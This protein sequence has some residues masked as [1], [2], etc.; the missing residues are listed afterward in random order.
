M[1]HGAA[2]IYLSIL[3]TFLLIEGRGQSVLDRKVFIQANDIRLGTALQLIADKGGFK[4]SYNSNIIPL[5][6]VV[7]LYAE[8]VSIEEALDRLLS[9]QYEYRQAYNFVML[10]YAPRELSMVLQESVNYPGLFVI[11]GQ[12]VDSQTRLPVMYASV[13]EKKLLQTV[14][15]DR[16]GFFTLKLKNFPQAINITVSKENYKEIS[17]VFL[18]E[19]IVRPSRRGVSGEYRDGDLARVERTRLGRLLVTSEQKIQSLNIG[20]FIAQAPVQFSLGPGLST[21]GSLSG[22][23]IN[24]FSFNATGGY[25][26]GV[27]G[28]EIGLLFNIN[29]KDAGW[30]QF[31]GAFNLTGGSVSGLQIGGLYNNVLD[32]ARA[33]QISLGHN[34]VAGSFHGMQVGGLYNQVKHNFDGMQISTG[35]NRVGGSFKG[36]QLG[37][38]FN[39]VKE[40]FSGVQLS[41]GYNHLQRN[42]N[43]FQAGTFNH[44]GN[45]ASGIR[46]ALI[47]NIS[48]GSTRGGQ[49]AGIFNYSKELKGFQAGLV[50]ISGTPGGYNF[51][52]VNIVKG[53]Y[54]RLSLSA[55]ES[56]DLN[57]ALKTGNQNL[58]TAL[59]Y[60]RNASST[61][62]LQ[63]IGLGF[64][65][66]LSIHKD[67]SLNPEISS[68]YIHQGNWKDTNLLNRLDLNLDYPLA[69]WISLNTGPAFTVFYSNQSVQKKDYAFLRDKGFGF[70]NP[71][72]RGWVGWNVGLSFSA[73]PRSQ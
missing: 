28:M 30:F 47:G 11:R 66:Q 26:A 35:H 36:L 46:V 20:N 64:G 21:H 60:G 44:T 37:A 53:G 63:A 31:G 50:N 70:G 59:L 6:S 14:L 1:K 67:L 43:G 72:Y 58:Y 5:D 62:K 57:L 54:H 39:L 32:S 9:K 12:I 51:G 24:R 41:L 22:Q 2:A 27:Q 56:I 61:D 23:V 13:Y 45:T 48:S 29:K 16:Q 4:F 25:T 68:R 69:K 71:R 18:A 73:A 17:T 34:R 10:R 55:N 40:D 19:V 7:N 3:L 65:K 42:F 49:A 38:V 52:L 8:N 15:T 33:G